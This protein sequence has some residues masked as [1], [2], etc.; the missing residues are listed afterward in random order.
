VGIATSLS[1]WVNVALLYIM[2]HRRDLLSLDSRLMGKVWRIL[3]AA[4]A[5]G[6]ALWFGGHLA[7]DWMVG[8][9]YH[10]AIGLTLLCGAGGMVYVLASFAFGAYRLSELKAVLKRRRA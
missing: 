2:L 7:D 6:V 5:M 3:A 9:W 8:D 4:V 1:A 10:R